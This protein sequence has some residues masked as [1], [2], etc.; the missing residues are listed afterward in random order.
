[1]TMTPRQRAIERISQRKPLPSVPREPV[2]DIFGRNVFSFPVMRAYLPADVWNSI[3]RTIQGEE[4]LDEGIADIVAEAMKAWAIERG[5]THYAHVFFPLTGQTA[6]KHDSFYDPA[7]N[8]ASIARFRG[9]A[10]IQ[11]QADASSFPS[12]GIRQTFEAR[13]YAIWDVSSPAYLY[14]SADGATLC[15]PTA[16]ISWTGEALDQKT[17]VLRSSQALNREAKRLLRLFGHENIDRV[18]ALCGPEQEYFLIDSNFYYLRPDLIH[19]GRALLGAAPPKGQ[20]FG[21][22]YFGAIPD[23]VLM[24]MAE[25]EYELFKLGVPAKTRHNEVAPSQYEIAPLFESANIATDHQA[26]TMMLLKRIAKKHGFECLTHEKPFSGVNGSG[27][28]VNWSLGNATQGNLLDPGDSPESNAQFLVFCAAVIRAIAKWGPLLNAMTASAGNDYR[29]GSSE[30]P[31]NILSVFLGKPLTQVYERLGSGNSKGQ[32]L[33]EN[34]KTGVEV[35]AD[36]LRDAGDRNRT[37]PFAF[38]GNRFEFRSVGADQ[39]IAGPIAMLN[40]IVADSLAYCSDQLEA[41]DRSTPDAFDKSVQT[42][43][44]ELYQQNK[45]ILFDGDGYSEH[46]RQEASRRGIPAAGDT[47]DIL[48][49]LNTPEVA[50]LL[51]HYGVLSERELQSRYDVYIDQ[52]IKRTW[53]EVKITLKIARTMILPAAMKHIRSLSENQEYLQ[54]LVAH[55][56]EPNEPALTRL[57]EQFAL[58]TYAL[59]Q[60]VEQLEQISIAAP[61]ESCWDTM[62]Y[63]HARLLPAMLKV[64]ECADSIEQSIDD[65]LWPLPTFQEMLFMK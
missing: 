47:P 51:S 48:L 10:L 22:H 58:S 9:S 65:S 40:T 59:T 31:P 54:S 25:V 43:I 52:Y 8:G 57:G 44:T 56:P 4:P 32:S 55:R 37:S 20:E 64:R 18:E 50:E 6:E 36:L 53:V 24:Y 33:R 12:G 13:G 35:L 41:A 7:A 46:W 11:S 62:K 21:D 60:A 27:K 29:L 39:S 14:D 38:V 2:P 3:E 26:L 63:H 45:H 5:A 42:L 15:I 61:E 1:M 19:A 17:P 16:F 23:R 30:A 28:H 34:L 49:A